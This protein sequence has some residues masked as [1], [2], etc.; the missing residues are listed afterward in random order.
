MGEGGEKGGGRGYV[1]RQAKGA[2][3]GQITCRVQPI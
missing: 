2:K 1:Q 3:D